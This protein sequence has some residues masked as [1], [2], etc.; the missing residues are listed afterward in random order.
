[1][2]KQNKTYLA[3]VYVIPYRIANV[4]YILNLRIGLYIIFESGLS[5]NRLI[6]LYTI[7][8]H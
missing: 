4:L 6:T 5:N 7:A 1:M 2:K 3:T 8:H